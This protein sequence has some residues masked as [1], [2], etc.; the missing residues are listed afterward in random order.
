M[1]VLGRRS[2]VLMFVLGVG[3]FWATASLADKPERAMLPVAGV[4]AAC[5]TGEDGGEGP[6]PGH[7]AVFTG[8]LSFQEVPVGRAPEIM[9]EV[10]DSYLSK[11]GQKVVPLKIVSIGGRAFAEGIGETQFWLDASRPV[12]SA[13]WEKSPGTEF[14]AVQEMRFHIFYTLEAMPG[15]VFRS[16]N[17]AILRSENVSAFPPLP[18]TVYRLVEPVQ[19]ED[20][21]EPGVVVGTLLRNQVTIPGRRYERTPELRGRE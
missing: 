5:A 16:I 8:G 15:R 20:V 2:L 3:A 9:V 10:G 4:K 21:K 17:P 14:P 13:I 19:L 1:K 12:T 11:R 18:G 7:E 6:H